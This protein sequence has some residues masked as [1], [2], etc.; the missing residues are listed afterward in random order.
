MSHTVLLINP[1][2]SR[3]TTDMMVAIAQAC[4]QS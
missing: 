3:P 4:F 1:N 2:T